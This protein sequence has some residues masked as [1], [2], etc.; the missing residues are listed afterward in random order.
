[1]KKLELKKFYVVLHGSSFNPMCVGPDYHVHAIHEMRYEKKL[2]NIFF[3]FY[4]E[5]VLFGEKAL[6]ECTYDYDVKD[7]KKFTVWYDDERD[8]R[9]PYQ[10]SKYEVKE[11]DNALARF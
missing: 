9:L 3:N 7:V 4:E 6:N 5:A 10:V 8:D 1:M 2:K 11:L